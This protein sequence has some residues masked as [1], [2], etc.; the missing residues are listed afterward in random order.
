MPQPAWV[1]RRD[2]LNDLVA[3]LIAESEVIAPRAAADGDVLFG[4]VASPDEVRWDYV[5][6][7]LPPKQFVLPQTDPLI[8]IRREGARVDLTPVA[9][10]RPLVLLGVRSCDARALAFLRKVHESDLPDDGYLRRA[11]ALTVVTMAC[12]TPCESGFCICCDAGPFLSAGFDLQLT[13][14][15]GSYLAEVGSERGQRLV[16]G[17]RDV[18]LPASPAHLERRERLAATA[19]A[20]FGA[21]TAHLGSAMRRISA[22]R[23]KDELWEAISGECFS[24]GS[25]NFVCPTCYCFSVHDRADDHGWLRCRLWD[26]C[27][28][29]AFTLEASG[30]NPRVQRKDR[31]KR[32]FFHKLSAQYFKRDGM[33]GCVGC[34]RC[35]RVCL[36]TTHMPAVV[37]AVRKGVWHA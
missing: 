9:D 37:A 11:D 28:F 20:S 17:A 3:R 29:P 7:L 2:G 36:G 25:C 5:N 21:S 18:F 34:G 26:S 23:V 19:A 6:T 24:C 30:H 16:V 13:D 27:Q 12:T 32:R 22:G 15:H 4:T 31:V 1:I 10:A 33:A 14:L 35:I 8:A